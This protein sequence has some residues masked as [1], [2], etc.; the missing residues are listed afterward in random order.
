M[1]LGDLINQSSVAQGSANDPGYDGQPLCAAAKRLPLAKKTGD[2]GLDRQRMVERRCLVRI[3]DQLIKDPRYVMPLH[4]SLL[5][6]YLNASP[7]KGRQSWSGD[8]KFLHQIP[9]AWLVEFILWEARRLNV[10]SSALLAKLEEDS[11]DNLPTL[12]SFM[13]QVPMSVQF[14]PCMKDAFVATLVFQRRCKQVGY[15]LAKFAA[16][17]GITPSGKFDRR[18]AGCY[19]MEFNPETGKRVKVLH[20]SGDE[21]VPPDHAP[22]TGDFCLADNFLVSKA[23]VV[24]NP[25]RD[26]L[27]NMFKQRPFVQTMW[28]PQKKFSVPKELAEKAIVEVDEADLARAEAS[29]TNAAAMDPAAKKRAAVATE[30]ARRALEEAAAKR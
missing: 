30:R 13:I 21:S 1:A 10:L 26:L 14:P 3:V 19:D 29:S 25:R 8:Y 23:C 5:V 24:L 22:V 15:R 2:T 20:I 28:Q 4:S 6:I 11:S 18:R 9:R 7:G 16:R 12:F 27:Y 17:G